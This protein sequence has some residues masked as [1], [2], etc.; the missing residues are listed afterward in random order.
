MFA[1][2]FDYHVDQLPVVN[3]GL[4]A[5]RMPRLGGNS[6]KKICRRVNVAPAEPVQG[7]DKTSHWSAGIVLSGAA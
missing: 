2:E 4:V 3:S 5:A 6:R 1:K 7:G